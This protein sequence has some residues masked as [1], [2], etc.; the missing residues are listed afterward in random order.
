MYNSIFNSTIV[1]KKIKT[2]FKTP[3]PIPKKYCIITT[4]GYYV[5]SLFNF[6]VLQLYRFKTKVALFSAKT[7]VTQEISQ[8]KL[9]GIHLFLNS[10]RNMFENPTYGRSL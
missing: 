3:H 7:K 8:K 9:L 6:L 5:N 2:E 4:Y 1:L 10:C